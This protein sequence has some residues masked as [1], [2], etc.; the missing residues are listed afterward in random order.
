MAEPNAKVV[1]LDNCLEVHCPCG[2]RHEITRTAEGK[3]EIETFHKAKKKDEPNGEPGTKKGGAEDK[4]GEPPGGPAPEH[5]PRA[6]EQSI[7]DNFLA[8]NGG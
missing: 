1:L 6:R 8:A 7:L 5:K 3:A 2:L 4:D